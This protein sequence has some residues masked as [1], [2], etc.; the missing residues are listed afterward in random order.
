MQVAGM[1]LDGILALFGGLAD[2]ETEL[3]DEMVREMLV[4]LYGGFTK[5]Y[6][7]FVRAL[8]ALAE[9]VAKDMGPALGALM[10]LIGNV[11]NDPEVQ[12]AQ[13]LLARAK[14]RNRMTAYRAYQAAGFSSSEAFELL[15]I[16]AGQTLNHFEAV[17][18]ALKS[19]NGG[20]AEAK[21]PR[22]KKARI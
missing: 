16:D 2:G 7:P 21:P 1:D 18:N 10:A 15:T 19:M 11:A 20:G 4:E 9:P 8:P 13:E 17:G 22:K 14:A 6:T 12:I 5:N 3:P